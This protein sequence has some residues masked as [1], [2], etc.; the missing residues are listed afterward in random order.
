ME[1]EEIIALGMGGDQIYFEKR[2]LLKVWEILAG[3]SRP[4]P[5]PLK[6]SLKI[7]AILKRRQAKIPHCCEGSLISNFYHLLIKFVNA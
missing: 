1:L 4:V 2:T 7:T 5:P 3:F 6:K